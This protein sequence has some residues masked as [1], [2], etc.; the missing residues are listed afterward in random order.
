VLLFFSILLGSSI[1][2]IGTVEGKSIDSDLRNNTGTWAETISGPIPPPQ[3]GFSSVRSVLRTTDGNLLMVGST[4]EFGVGGIGQPCF[5]CLVSP[6]PDVWLVKLDLAGRFLWQRTYGG[7][8]A[9]YGIDVV[10]ANRG[11]Y[12]VLASTRSFGCGDLTT[13]NNYCP[14]IFKV[15]GN[16]KLLWQKILKP[17]GLFSSEI[18]IQAASDGGLTLAGLIQPQGSSGGVGFHDYLWLVKVGPR[19]DIVWQKTYGEFSNDSWGLSFLAA[20]DAYVLSFV[21]GYG[22]PIT[23]ILKISLAGNVAWENQ[24]AFTRISSIDSSSDGQY[25]FGGTTLIGIKYQ[26]WV[27]KLDA[28][29]KIIWQVYHGSEQY[30]ETSFIKHTPDGG[31]IIAGFSL[32]SA[33]AAQWRSWVSKLDASGRILWQ[34]NITGRPKALPLADNGYIVIQNLGVGVNVSKLDS[35]GHCCTTM[36]HDKWATTESKVQTWTNQFYKVSLTLTVILSKT[37]ATSLKSQATLSVQCA[38]PTADDDSEG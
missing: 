24:Y 31:Y 26:P 29:G 33:F 13:L 32:S 11:E 18:A 10:Q 37:H 1:F 34:N 16:G 6:L 8:L 17:Q 22:L 4:N 19:G 15:N 36:N 35:L 3:F 21:S 2:M 30:G 9:D 23:T 28:A 20:K 27:I 7:P 12:F 14:W 38:V 5:A 25:V